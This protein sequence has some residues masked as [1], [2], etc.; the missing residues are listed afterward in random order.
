MSVFQ[1]GR[2][3]TTQP[4]NVLRRRDAEIFL[5]E[6]DHIA[7][8]GVADL[9]L[10][11]ERGMLFNFIVNSL[12]PVGESLELYSELLPFFSKPVLITEFGPAR[13]WEILINRFRSNPRKNQRERL[14]RARSACSSD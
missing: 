1:L 10:S 2:S 13:G 4:S 11:P 3:Y 14:R 6:I 8:I 7:E 12:S 5:D 9:I